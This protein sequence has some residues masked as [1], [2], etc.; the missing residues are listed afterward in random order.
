LYGG[1]FFLWREDEEQ[2]SPV[3]AASQGLPVKATFTGIGS[4]MSAV[5]NYPSIK[6][7]ADILFTINRLHFFIAGIS[8]MLSISHQ[9][10]FGLASSKIFIAN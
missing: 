6:K 5:I 9:L 1:F 10:G 8:A 3:G 2:I 7:L 4:L